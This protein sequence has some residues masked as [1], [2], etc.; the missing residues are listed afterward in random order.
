ML[1]CS[2]SGR[3]DNPFPESPFFPQSG[4]MHL[5]SE[6]CP[7]RRDVDHVP[8]GEKGDWGYLYHT[9]IF[10]IVIRIAENIGPC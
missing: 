1:L 10:D 5:A 3:Y 9:D 6:Q 2:L 4:S 7:E 8:W